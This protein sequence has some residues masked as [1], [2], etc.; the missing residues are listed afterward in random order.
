MLF[1]RQLILD[2]QWDDVIE[3]VQPLGSIEGFNL[4][5]NL[6]MA[7][8]YY[9][10]NQFVSLNLYAFYVCRIKYTFSYPNKQK[11]TE[12]YVIVSSST[13]EEVSNQEIKSV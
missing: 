10:V 12:G 9:A 5:P 3:F 13:Q 6:T 2:G 11:R 7:L 1:L 4:L 8:L